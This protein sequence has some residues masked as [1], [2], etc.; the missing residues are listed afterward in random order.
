MDCKLLLS[1]IPVV[2]LLAAIFKS[3][4]V[5][6]HHLRERREIRRERKWC[7]L[8]FLYFIITKVQK[9]NKATINTQEALNFG[10]HSQ[11]NSFTF[12]LQ[13]NIYLHNGTNYRKE[14]NQH[15]WK[16]TYKIKKETKFTATCILYTKWMN[17]WWTTFTNVKGSCNSHNWLA[18]RVQNN[19][20]TVYEIWIHVILVLHTKNTGWW[21]FTV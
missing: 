14:R 21:V 9:I 6:N 18:H 11:V 13:N 19:F 20:H 15:S 17:E 12:F 7:L 10:N 5:V 1:I 8:V 2:K 4:H 16:G 3:Q